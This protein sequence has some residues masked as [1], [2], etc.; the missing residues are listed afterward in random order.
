METGQT[1]FKTKSPVLLCVTK[2][3]ILNL[4]HIRKVTEI[5]LKSASKHPAREQ[6]QHGNVITVFCIKNVFSRTGYC[7]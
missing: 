1:Q 2:H 6:S 7:H 3:I 4:L 5:N